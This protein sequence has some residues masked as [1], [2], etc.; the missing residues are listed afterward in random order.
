MTRE[1]R[2][3]HWHTPDTPGDIC[4]LQ[5]PGKLLVGRKKP[6]KLEKYSVRQRET[7]VSVNFYSRK[8]LGGI[9]AYG[10]TVEAEQAVEMAERVL[11]L[12][13]EVMRRQGKR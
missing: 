11:A 4:P 6:V 9:P 10:I 1:S 13:K 3:E 2:L 7:G 5:P 8:V 12:A